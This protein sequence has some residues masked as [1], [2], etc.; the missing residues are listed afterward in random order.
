MFLLRVLFVLVGVSICFSLN[1]TLNE[2]FDLVVKNVSNSINISQIDTVVLDNLTHNW[3]QTFGFLTI[4]GQLLAFSGWL[5]YFSSLKR[6]GDVI[7]TNLNETVKMQIPLKFENLEIGYDNYSTKIFIPLN[8]SVVA[9]VNDNSI[10]LAVDVNKTADCKVGVL[11]SFVRFD[12]LNVTTT[13]N[14]YFTWFNNHISKALIQQFNKIK[15]SVE[16][17]LKGQ[18]EASVQSLDLCQL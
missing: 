18:F 6:D 4:R 15:S 9:K 16:S 13:G 5:K 2:Q 14:T 8:G 11:V 17:N 12:N 3:V 1:L 7:I 10:V